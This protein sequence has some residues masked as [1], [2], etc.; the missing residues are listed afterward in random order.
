VKDTRKLELSKG[1]GELRFM[2]VA[3]HIMPVTVHA[4]SVNIPTSA[5]GAELQHDLITQPNFYKYVGKKIKIMAGTS[6]RTE[7]VV[8]LH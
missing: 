1:Q 8:M 2:D 4:K 5:F 7:R 6:I 3:S